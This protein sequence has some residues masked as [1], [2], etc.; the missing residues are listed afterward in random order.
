[1]DNKLVKRPAFKFVAGVIVGIC[2]SLSLALLVIP[3]ISSDNIY[4]QIQK[5]QFIL[6]SVIKNYFEEVDIVKVNEGG[7]KGMLK[8][9][10]P[11]SQYIS[12]KDFKSMNEEMQGSF[13][14]IGV[15]F[16]MINDT[17]V[18]EGVIP[19]GPSEKIGIRARDRIIAADGNSLVGVRQDSVPKVLRGPKGTI[20]NLSIHR[21]GER[22]LLDFR[23]TRDKL[24][25]NSI[26]Y[27][28]VIE[29]TDIGYI[30]L[31]TYAA[32]THRELVDSAKKLREQGM[33]KLIFDLRGNGGGMLDIANRV[34]D[35]FLAGDTIVYTKG[36]DRSNDRSYT[37]RPGHSLEDIPL[38]VLIDMG[39]ASASEITAGAVQDLDRGLVV[40]ITSFG[41]GTVQSQQQLNDGSALR[42]TTAAFYTASGRCIQRPFRDIEAWRKMTDRLELEEGYNLEHILDKIKK[43]DAEKSKNGKKKSDAK[44]DKSIDM[45]SIE[46]F[47]TRTGRPVLGGGGI[48]PDYVVKYD[49]SRL[50]DLAAQLRRQDAYHILKER[51]LEEVQKQF[52]NDFAK[53]NKEFVFTDNMLKELKKIAKEKE[54]EW[55]DEQ[56]ETDKNWIENQQMKHNF[57]RSIWNLNTAMQISI[58]HDRQVK[59]AMEL[60]PLAEKIYASSQ[61]R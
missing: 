6:S 1:M 50:T 53:F 30:R 17:I 26:R 49:T 15:Q 42:L 27:S 56:Y 11:H 61:K 4:N 8:E 29:G 37:A 52:G 47:Y 36:R 23:V 33:K 3:I 13:D 59:K 12:S 9:L 32:T 10:D 31:A 19:D 25:L 34:C 21:P 54:I 40:G 24:P 20:V 46:I 43:E 45:D 2:I 57:A 60:F 16:M 41:K 7:I 22:E 58:L 14:G 28:F 5:Y 44:D 51:F 39:S 35:E 38:I 55:N 48:T 18:I